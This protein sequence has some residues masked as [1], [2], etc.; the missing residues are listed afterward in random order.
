MH[1][2]TMAHAASV[3][4]IAI[5]SFAAMSATV[6]TGFVASNGVTP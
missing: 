3:L 4:H 5:F 2:S 6:V 1:A